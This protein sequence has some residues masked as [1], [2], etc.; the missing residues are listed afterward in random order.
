MNHALSFLIKE[1]QLFDKIRH[2]IISQKVNVDDDVDDDVN[3]DV[4]DDDVDN[5]HAPDDDALC[6][7]IFTNH[8]KPTIWLFWRY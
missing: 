1:G 4:D 2:N 7:G 8:H 5:H 6:C 3:D